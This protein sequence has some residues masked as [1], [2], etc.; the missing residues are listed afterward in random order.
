MPGDA[1]ARPA[2]GARR[3]AGGLDRRPRPRARAGWPLVPML[4]ATPIV[5][6]LAVLMTIAALVERRFLLALVTGAVRGAC[7]SSRSRRGRSRNAHRTRPACGCAC[8]PP[9]WPPTRLRR[10]GSSR[11]RAEERVDVM[12]VLELPPAVE[13]AYESAGI[14]D[15][16]P[17]AGAAAAAR[18]H[19]HRAVLARAAGRRCRD[20]PDTS[21]A[22]AAAVARPPGAAP[23]EILA[24]HVQA[25]TTAA[26]TQ[27]WRPT[28]A[29]CPAGGRAADPGRRLQRDA[30]PRRAARPARPRLPRRRRAGRERPAPDLAAGAQPPPA[31]RDDR[32]RARRPPR[33]RRLRAQSCGSR[34]RTTAAC[35]PSC[36]CRMPT[37]AVA[38]LPPRA[39]V[40]PP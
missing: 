19:R 1:A 36:C 13:R 4:A 35:S 32:P 21:F 31:A 20:S 15:V 18:L 8:W 34:A 37:G 2:L 24:V 12:A 27:V 26:A 28:C 23:V 29:R 22:T 33:A 39:A 11:S 14:A 17:G 3:R 6:A 30:R 40:R 7:S 5:A 25:P 9:T 10:R 38:R 16:L